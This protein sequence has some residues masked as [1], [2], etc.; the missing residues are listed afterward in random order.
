MSNLNIT[1]I[2]SINSNTSP[3]EM[4]E[5]SFLNFITSAKKLEENHILLKKEI[6]D[7]KEELKQKDIEIKKAENLAT[8]GQTAAYLAHEIRNPLGAMKLFLSMLKNQTSNNEE[9]LSTLK[10]IDT[11]V[12]KLDNVVSNVLQF[13][14]SSKETFTP[15]NIKSII[16]E[17]LSLIK[18]VS[19]KDIKIVEN[20]DDDMMFVLGSPNSLKR[21]FNNLFLNALQAQKE[22]AYIEVNAKCDKEKITI[23][24]SDK[25]CGIDEK[26]IDKI[27]DPFIST[28]NEGT[29]LGLSVVK[30]ILNDHNASISANNIKNNQNII[31]ANFVIEFRR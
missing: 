12:S 25:G 20:Y 27:F 6:N 23:S 15:I 14:K 8:I 1:N 17:E 18:T 26:V 19:K 13:A 31:G 22:N 5:A 10:Q 21:V 2:T 24:I 16:K 7:L 3:S 9:A 4:L 30:K 11:C 28:K 29:G